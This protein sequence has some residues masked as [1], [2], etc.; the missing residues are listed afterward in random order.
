MRIAGLFVSLFT[1]TFGCQTRGSLGGQAGLLT[2]LMFVFFLVPVTAHA[3][4]PESSNVENSSS[5]SNTQSILP[6]NM[7]LVPDFATLVEQVGSSVVNIS[8]TQTVA[9]GGPSD[10]NLPEG[11]PFYELFKE[12]GGTPQ[13][14]REYEATSLGSGFILSADGL[15]MTNHHVI[16]GAD[17]IVVKLQDQRQLTAEIIGSDASSDIA[18]LK[19]EATDLPAVK[20]GNSKSLRVGEWV[21]AIGSPLGFEYSVTSGI[22]SAKNRTFG[23]VDRYVPFIQ[24]DVAIN[25][26]NSGGPLFNMRGEVIGVNSRISTRSGGYMGLSFAIPIDLAMNISTQ[27]QTGNVKRGWLGV[28]LQGVDRSLA[29]AMQLDKPEGALINEVFP[30]SPADEAGFQSGD[31]ILQYN[32]RKV[33]DVGALPPMVGVTAVGDTVPVQIIRDGQQQ[34]L[35]VTIGELDPNNN[36][37]AT[38]RRSGDAQTPKL[39]VAVQ[40]LTQ[41][42]RDEINLASGGVL[43]KS[44]AEGSAAAEAEIM[45]G[46]VLLSIDRKA[47]ESASQFET[48]VQALPT[49]RSMLVLVLRQ[50]RQTYRAIRLTE[51]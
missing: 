40:S 24:T 41:A 11:H 51:E 13:Q 25:P 45:P 16:D 38:G 33:I 34:T 17:E 1:I 46:D 2:R 21:M 5:Q 28:S 47:I 20:L 37:V 27:L 39:G 50:G 48:L 6:P 3:Q 36:G 22:V 4:A 19:V 9:Q 32:G 49:D 43:V 31:V 18:I 15:I 14:P 29:E 30:G 44:V 23:S 10:F 35:N 26:G 7:M 42:Q 12:Y 8:T